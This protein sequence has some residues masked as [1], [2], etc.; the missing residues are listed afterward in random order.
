MAI[1]GK[2]ELLMEWNDT[3]AIDHGE[4]DRD[5]KYLFMLTNR[6]YS[7][8]KYGLKKTEVLNLLSEYVEY[9]AVHYNHEEM[10]MSRIHYPEMERHIQ[11]HNIF[12]EKACDLLARYERNDPDIIAKISAY[13]GNYT[14]NHI[15]VYDKELAEY[16]HNLNQFEL[17]NPITSGN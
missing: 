15:D 9:I 7:A 14:F 5:H 10:L 13:V 3:L 11:A 16:C 6:I 8:A 12:F 2:A 17:L 4:I 1:G